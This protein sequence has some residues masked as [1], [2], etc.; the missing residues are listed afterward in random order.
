V[1]FAGDGY[2]GADVMDDGADQDEDGDAIVAFDAAMTHS[3]STAWRLHVAAFRN[4]SLEL[5][6]RSMVRSKIDVRCRHKEQGSL[7]GHLNKGVRGAA[8]RIKDVDEMFELLTDGGHQLIDIM[9]DT[10]NIDISKGQLLRLFAKVG[11]RTINLMPGHLLDAGE[12]LGLG[13]PADSAPS[14]LSADGKTLQL[15]VDVSL[16]RKAAKPQQPQ[17]PAGGMAEGSSAQEQ[18][19]PSR[20]PPWHKSTREMLPR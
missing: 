15:W 4:S 13:K 14:S 11:G 5:R 3:T 7:I 18:G 8:N 12:W 16:P 10:F 6:P 2:D 9:F 1:T 19:K 20:D 17:Q